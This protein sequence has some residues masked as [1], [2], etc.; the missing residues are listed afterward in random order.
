VKPKG[1]VRLAEIEQAL[2]EAEA[3][4]FASDKEVRA[5]IEKFR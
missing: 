2:K 4:D 5:M 3:G 1:A